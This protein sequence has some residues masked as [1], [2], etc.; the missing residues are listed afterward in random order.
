MTTITRIHPYLFG[1]GIFMISFILFMTMMI[2]TDPLFNYTFFV[3][4]LAVLSLISTIM[5]NIYKLIL[6]QSVEIGIIGQKLDDHL[7]EFEKR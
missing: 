2:I 1:I 5:L 4:M 3:I 7:F 6:R